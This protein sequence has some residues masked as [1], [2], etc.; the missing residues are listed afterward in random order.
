MPILAIVDNGLYRFLQRLGPGIG[1]GWW[2]SRS[3]TG[4]A[5]A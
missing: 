1:P 2:S 5:P 4:L 3:R